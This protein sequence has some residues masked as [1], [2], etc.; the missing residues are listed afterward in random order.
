MKIIHFQAN[1]ASVCG[2][3]HDDHDRLGAHKIRPAMVVCPGGGY[4][5][6]SPR[7]ADDP[8]MEFFVL[9]YNVFILRYSLGEQARQLRPLSELAETV[10][11]VRENAESWHIDSEKIAVMGFSAGGHL[12]ASLGA[13]WQEYSENARPNALVLCYPV[14][15]MG[16]FTHR[17]SRDNV[18]GGDGK[19]TEM[20]SI[21][22]HVTAD[23]PPSFVWG[24]VDDG[25]V[26][27]ENGLL[28][29]S[30]LRRAGVPFEYHLFT[31]GA[32]GLSVC[33]QEVETPS[34]ECRP[35]VALAQTWLN[36]QFL[37]VP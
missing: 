18:T 10:K 37:F 3:L 13:Y 12:A 15:T 31:H 29:V 20:L 11:I 5:H 34:P 32:H 23:F 27:M 17:G 36:G 30:A 33:T 9:G 1:A 7:E 28:L 25:S 16:E 14:I 22:N 19:L 35:W 2:Y 24:T 26:P 4:N 8:A 6:L 21:E